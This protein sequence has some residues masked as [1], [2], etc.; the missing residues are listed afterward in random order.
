M[1]RGIKSARPHPGRLNAISLSLGTALAVM[2]AA[3]ARAVGCT[4]ANIGANITTSVAAC[5]TW[6]GSNFTVSNSGI[7]TA[8]TGLAALTANTTSGTLTNRGTITGSSSSFGVSIAAGQ[9]VTLIDNS[10]S[11][12]APLGVAN[13]G[14]V[15][16]LSNQLTGLMTAGSIGHALNNISIGT[17][18]LLSNAGTISSAVTNLVNAGTIGAIINTGVIIST[19]KSGLDNYTGGTIGTLTNSGTI[20]GM[21]GLFNGGTIGNLS[22]S[23]K[24]TATN[25]GIQNYGTIGSLSNS[26]TISGGK[27]L[28]SKGSVGTLNNTGLITGTAA[29]IYLDR[30]VSGTIVTAV[31]TLTNFTNTGTV[32][33]SIY[34]AG[35]AL[36]ISGGTGSTF[37][38]LTGLAGAVGAITSTND[39]TFGSGNQLLNDNITVG[40]GPARSP[41]P[42]C[43]R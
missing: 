6:T 39:L 35:N 5:F 8:P 24:I 23:G 2:A 11:I 29:A 41:T 19:S 43:C 9:A 27:G 13:A 42:A 34:N 12:L 7:I 16:T 17:I 14:S 33:G 26:G 1:T 31:S 21:T 38:T 18:G 22:N 40:A 3:D 25:S 30:V 32:A 37:G 20:S 36:T 28:Y 15:G 4:T 10:G